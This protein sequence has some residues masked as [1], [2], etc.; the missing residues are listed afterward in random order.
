MKKAPGKHPDHVTAHII[1]AEEKKRMLGNQANQGNIQTQIIPGGLRSQSDVT[2]KTVAPK[3]QPESDSINDTQ[4]DILITGKAAIKVAKNVGSDHVWVLET[5]EA[6]SLQDAQELG[7]A[8]YFDFEVFDA[9]TENES[10]EDEIGEY[11]EPDED[12]VNEIL[13]HDSVTEIPLEESEAIL[14]RDQLIPEPPRE[15]VRPPRTVAQTMQEDYEPTAAEKA[16]N[17]LATQYFEKGIKNTRLNEMS[18]E[19]RRE[20]SW[21]A[22]LSAPGLQVYMH[23]AGI[24]RVNLDGKIRIQ[25]AIEGNVRVLR[26]TR[27]DRTVPKSNIVPSQN[28]N[29]RKFQNQ[30]TITANSGTD[31]NEEPESDATEF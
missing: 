20:L 7:E 28:P 16:G 3:T 30:D 1:T 27:L 9:E 19:Q 31:K 23:P 2:I 29:V 14:A 12:E 4:E 13:N 24:V 15:T 6:V 25:K 21:G 22:V 5:G 26:L 18:P 17:K 11:L 8:V 10:D